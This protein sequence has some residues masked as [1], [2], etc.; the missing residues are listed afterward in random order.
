MFCR[1]LMSATAAVCFAAAA[2]SA[3][4][5]DQAKGFTVEVPEG[6]TKEPGGQF[7]LDL[8][9]L[10]PRRETT[11]GV[12]LLMSQEVKASKELTQVELNAVVREQANEEFWRAILTADKTVQVKD[13][14]IKASHET[15]GERAV[16]RATVLVTA[17][18]ENV[19]TPFQ[20]EMM[21]QALPGHSY[22]THCAVKQDQVAAE[23]AD[24]KIVIDTHTPTG[25][26]G[27]IASA[28]PSGAVPVAAARVTLGAATD[29]FKAGVG[30]V[31]KRTRRR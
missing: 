14:T 8:A 6:W 13:M 29:A 31:V 23:A 2:A 3:P 4:Y 1:F 30:E 25:T 12:C 28:K 24:I 10:S 18:S 21:L 7:P 26:A 5:A 20:F 19:T 22:L 15:R 9:L 16:A 11:N 27:V 17:T